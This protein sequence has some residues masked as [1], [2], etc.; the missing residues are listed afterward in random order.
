MVLAMV[1]V[2]SLVY[3]QTDAKNSSIAMAKEVAEIESY[4]KQ[5]D[6]FIKRN[7]KSTRIFAN[8]SA[9]PPPKARWREFKSD[10]EIEKQD[11]G[12][13]LNESAFVWLRGNMIVGAN[14]TFQS[15]S[16]DWAHYVMHYFN[17]AG[18]LVKTHSELYT[19]YGNMGVIRDKV[20]N[21]QGKVIKSSTHFQDLTTGKKK[22]PKDDF[23]DNSPP[24]Y[25]DVKKLPFIHLLRTG[26]N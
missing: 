24:I 25:R 26:I 4:S 3:P 22:T 9:D 1:L 6:R 10:K 16:R 17:E 15:P 7:P 2:S 23:I 20:Y 14:F 11:S 19:F 8:I 5:I 21:G 12:D 18:T 13:N